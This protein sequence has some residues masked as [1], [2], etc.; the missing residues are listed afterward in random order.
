MKEK[1]LSGNHSTGR[2]HVISQQLLISLISVPKSNG[3]I[4]TEGQA[5]AEGVSVVI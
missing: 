4:K 5:E 3:S 2:R 1:S